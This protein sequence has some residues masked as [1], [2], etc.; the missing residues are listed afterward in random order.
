VG[1][2]LDAG[3]ARGAVW[4]YLQVTE[5]NTAAAALYASLGFSDLYRYWYRQPPA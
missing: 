5:A 4:A 2:V 3:A 1:A